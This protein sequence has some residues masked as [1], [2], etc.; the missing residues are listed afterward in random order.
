MLLPGGSLACNWWEESGPARRSTIAE[1]AALQLYVAEHLK[2]EEGCPQ[3]SPFNEIDKCADCWDYALASRTYPL[4]VLCSSEQC[5]NGMLVE[6]DPPFGRV[7]DRH[8]RCQGRGWVPNGDTV[9][10]MRE[11][12]LV[13]MNRDVPA[14]AWHIRFLAGDWTDTVGLTVRV[15]G[16][17]EAIWEAE[18]RLLGWTEAAPI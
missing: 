5:D 18:A 16:H 17:E 7:G 8:E 2:R 1:L 6:D 3:H 9:V 14:G 4:R 10:L 13:D 15:E 11:A 12:R